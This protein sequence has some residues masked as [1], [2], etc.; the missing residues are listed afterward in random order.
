MISLESEELN[1]TCHIC[2][3]IYI[4]FCALKSHSILTARQRHCLKGV[5]LMCDMR[6][7]PGKDYAS[8]VTVWKEPQCTTL[9]ECTQG[10][11]TLGSHSERPSES[12]RCST[13]PSLLLDRTHM[14]SSHPRLMCAQVGAGAMPGAGGHGCSRS[15]TTATA[16]GTRTAGTAGAVQVLRRGS[17]SRPPQRPVPEVHPAS[18]PSFS[19]GCFALWFLQLSTSLHLQTSSV[20]P[21]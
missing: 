3:N 4:Y 7:E 10:Q 14:S 12:G 15:G 17:R 16:G 8:E 18:Q 1:N 2:I 5:T 19:S 20:S 6:T 21:F 11:G 9:S 13:H